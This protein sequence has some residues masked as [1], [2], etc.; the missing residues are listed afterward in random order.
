MGPIEV[1]II[2]ISKKVVKKDTCKLILH[3]FR[4]KEYTD[5]TNP[6]E[7][8]TNV[9]MPVDETLA[10][11]FK[12]KDKYGR[13]YW[14]MTPHDKE[15]F[16]YMLDKVFDKVP[17]HPDF[18]FISYMQVIEYPMDTMCNQHKDTGDMYD[19]ATAILVLDDDFEG[20]K[21]SVD[22]IVIDAKQ[23]DLVMFNHSTTTYHG[24]SPVTKGVRTVLALWFQAQH[25]TPE[26][27]EE[28]IIDDKPRFDE[29]SETNTY[30]ALL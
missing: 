30:N 18:E 6:I 19:T 12:Y 8:N 26:L 2:M 9:V 21:F 29:N 5:V 28:D 17:D 14:T 3:K 22:D 27:A 4:N 10:N 20:G 11:N 13:T 23:G 1:P 15:D 24:V 7:G 25:S 16:I